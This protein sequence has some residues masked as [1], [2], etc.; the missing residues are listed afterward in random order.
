MVGAAGGVLDGKT[1]RKRVKDHS[2]NT[3]PPNDLNR[4]ISKLFKPFHLFLLSKG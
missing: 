4:S 3:R 1:P 2:G